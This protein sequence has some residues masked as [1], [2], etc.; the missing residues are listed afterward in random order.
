MEYPVRLLF[1]DILIEAGI[2]HVFGLPGGNTPFIFDGFVDKKDHFKTYL[3]RH[4]GGAAVMA[5]MYSR[6]TG[7][8]AV[9]VGQGPWIATSGGYGI[10]ES[11]MSGLPMIIIC[12][13]SDYYSLPQFAP[14]QN[15][16]GDYG[17]VDLQAMMKSMTKFTTLATNPSEF[18]HGLQL[19]IKHATTGRPGPAA[20]LI[21]WNIPFE[22]IDMEKV[23]PKFYPVSGYL[24]DSPPCLSQQHATEIA[25]QLLNA[26]NPIMICGQG[27]RGS[28]AYEEVKELA[29]LI[30]LPVATSYLGKSTL[31]ETHDCALGTMGA[32][33]QKIANSKITEADLILTVGSSLA[34][35]NTK[36]M[37]A[38][39]I[40]P[41][42]QTIIQIDIDSRNTG[43][44]YPISLGVTSDAKL[45]LS[46]ITEKI[47]EIG[48]PFDVNQRIE[49]LKQEKSDADY[50]SES[51]RNSTETPI[52]P[53]RVVGELNKL[54]SEND[55]LVLDG[56]NNRMWITHHF[57]TNTPGQILAGG[58]A[59]AVG[60]GPPAAVSAQLTAPDKKVICVCGDGGMMMQL[61]AI[62]MARDLNL[63]VVFLVLNNSC[64]GN[65]RDYQAPERRIATEYSQTNFAG[66]AEGSGI[67][68]TR[69]D[70]P[71]KLHDVLSSA[72][73]SNKPELIEVIVN[74]KPHFKLMS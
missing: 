69:V 58:G 38:D 24:K 33:G 6:I 10:V 13:T 52:A 7:K 4:E 28:S 26:G 74:D 70:D 55:L 1:A 12:D 35:D 51:I 14:Y 30:G 53:E 44:T 62:E 61:Y 25:T 68:G 54:V 23:H 47:K 21:R 59:A 9:L 57:Q 40:N 63:P 19:A 71:E 60:Y 43:W 29:E 31:P 37:A 56:G 20:V 73:K 2:D 8:P 72:L 36:W 66:I 50:F 49:K 15:A 39:Y 5:D 41:E 42:K 18:L 3:A 48:I 22:K 46:A 34:P 45:A 11:Y 32:I 27:A 65:V 67:K 17:S 16:S 64:L